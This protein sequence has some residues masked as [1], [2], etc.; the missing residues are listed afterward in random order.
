VARGYTLGHERLSALL[1]LDS[2]CSWY[3]RT[4]QRSS[5]SYTGT[6]YRVVAYLPNPDHIGKVV[7][8]RAQGSKPPKQRVNF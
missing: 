1:K 8:L 6:G 5:G 7:I 4:L 2:N 3:V